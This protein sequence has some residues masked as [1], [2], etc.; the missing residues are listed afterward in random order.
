MPGYAAHSIYRAR[1]LRGLCLSFASDMILLVR[2]IG[3]KKAQ[4]CHAFD[5]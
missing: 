3:P 2:I 4:H 5:S 1:V